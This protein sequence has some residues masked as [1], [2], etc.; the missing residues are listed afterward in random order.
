VEPLLWRPCGWVRLEFDVA[1]RRNADRTERE[2][3][4]TTKALLPVGTRDEARWL[5][6]RVLP[7]AVAELP[8]TAGV[9]GRALWRV[10]LS[11][12]YA[13]VH[14]DDG[15]VACCT[16]RLRPDTVIVP[17]QKV[18]SVRWSQ[19]PWS[20]RLRI[21]SIFID[22]AGHRFTGNARFRD[23][24]EAQRMLAELPD[25]ARVARGR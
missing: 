17:L 24:A 15:Y 3:G 22:T 10:P 13:R 12:R 6:S 16:G 19:G 1:R 21:G 9:P 25:L 20:R 8:P 23:E 18:Q 14:Y 5:L 4:S 2:S 7:G 11:R